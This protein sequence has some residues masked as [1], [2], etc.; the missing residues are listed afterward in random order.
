MSWKFYLRFSAFIQYIFFCLTLRKVME[1]VSL[2]EEIMAEKKRPYFSS[3]DGD[4]SRIGLIILVFFSPYYVLISSS[5]FNSLSFPSFLPSLLPFLLHFSF[6]L[7][8]N[9][10]TCLVSELYHF[11][12]HFL[13]LSSSSPP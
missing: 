12:P 8:T 10:L 11:R 1:F 7:L 4:F 3:P 9:P 13:Q 6:S 5:S 2:I